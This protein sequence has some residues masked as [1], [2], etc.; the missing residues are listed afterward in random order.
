MARD[1]NKT[2]KK[3]VLKEDTKKQTK[4]VNKKE[5][6]VVSAEIVKK[7]NA[8]KE[9]TNNSKKVIEEPVVEK[10]TV[11]E[12][13]MEKKKKTNV[14][15]V[16]DDN[17]KAILFCIVGFLLA[18]LLFRFVLWPDRIA[19][20]ADGTQPVANINGEAY[21]ADKLY[22]K[23]KKYYSINVLL[24][25]IDDE[26]LT[27]IYPEDEDMKE[28]VNDTAEYYYEYYNQY[29]Q[30]TKEQFLSNNGFAKEE[31][32]LDTLRLDYRR[33]EYY[34]DYAKGL[35]KEEEVNKYYKDEVYGDINSK[36]MLVKVAAK[37]GAEGLKDAEAKK[38][39]K[40][41]ISK[42]NSGKTWDEVKEEYK[43]KIVAEDLGYNAYNASF[44]APYLKECRKL[45]VGKYSK[46][47]VKT[48]YGY[49]VI[50]KID[51]KE[52]PKLEEVKDDI[53]ETLAAKIK[54]DDANLYY[55]ALISLREE[56]KLEFVD[57]KFAEA[58][59]N[60]VNTYNKKQS[61]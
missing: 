29:Y 55:K 39:V 46:E 49:H 61:K 38:L 7:E 47:P 3:N 5:E 14:I 12:I 8:Q 28:S 18:T 26:L 50:F 42:L 23:M 1:V 35:V 10:E 57:S 43:D 33:N 24:N 60:Y 56:A 41:I 44:E 37:E 59:K 52:T 53:I 58:Y 25:D 51:Q 45:E 4:T 30:Y 36:H 32:F 9:K 48:S 19:T 21:T 22:E 20:L 31:D 27:E 2:Q 11:K 34:E 54:K 16:M 13:K 40:E 17:R 15:K 6:K